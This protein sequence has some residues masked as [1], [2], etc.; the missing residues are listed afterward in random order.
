[1]VTLL[2]V[3]VG[4]A[5]MVGKGDLAMKLAHALVGL[6]LVLS[7]APG[8]IASLNSELPS[9]G[10]QGLGEVSGLASS[11]ILVVLLAGA[12]L[13][14]W[15]ARGLLAKRREATARRWGSPRDRS[16]PP[17][18]PSDDASERSDLS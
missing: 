11:A 12:G 14:L 1:M 3:F 8:L 4:I 18:P 9:F 5:I 6:V 7:F 13:A 2:I 17:P 10:C 15:R 16:A